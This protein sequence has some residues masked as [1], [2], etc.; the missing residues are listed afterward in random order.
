M[1]HYVAA[2]AVKYDLKR[3]CLQKLAHDDKRFAI[4][5]VAAAWHEHTSIGHHITMPVNN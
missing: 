2:T 1:S 5:E 4:S 3:L